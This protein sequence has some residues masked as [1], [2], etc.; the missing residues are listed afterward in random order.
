MPIVYA[1]ALLIGLALALGSWARS[2]RAPA[3][4]APA[5]AG[6]ASS[7]AATAPPAAEEPRDSDPILRTSEGLRRKVV[8]KQLGVVCRSD[9]QGGR[10]VGAP[11][12]YFAICFLYGQR[13]DEDP[14]V[15]QVGPREGPAQ[16]W[17][18]ASAVLEWDTRLMARPTPRRGRPPLVIYREE[19]CLLDVL[20]R[21]TCPRHRGRCPTEGEEAAAGSGTTAPA[22]GMP[23]LKSR[24]LHQADGSTRTV[25]RVASL[26]RD[27]GRPKPPPPAPPAEL[28]PALRQ[29]DIAFVIDTTASMQATIDAARSLAQRLVADAAQRHRDVALR[30]GLVAYRDTSPV[31][32]YRSKIVSPLTDP[33]SFLLALRGLAA[34]QRADGSIEESVLDGVAQALPPLPGERAGSA[35]LQ[36]PAGRSGELATKLVVLLGDAPDHARDLARAEALAAHARTAGITIATVALDRPGVLSRAERARYEAQWRALAA[37]SFLPRDKASG[38]ARRVAPLNL[39]PDEAGRLVPLLESIIDDRIEHARDLAALAAA[40]AEGRLADYVNAQGLRLDQVAPVLVD[41]HRGEPAA[42]ARPDPRAQGK[43]APSVRTGWIAER[44]QGQ[45]LVTVEILMT[46]A[47]LDALVSELTQLQMAAQGTARELSDLLQIGTAAAAGETSFLAAD[48]GRQTFADHLRRRRGLPPARPDSL[49]QRT[50]ADLL[51]SD[52]AAR[53]ALDARL[54]SSLAELIRLRHTIAWDDPQRTV[55]GMALIPYALVDF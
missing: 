15:L 38:F 51:Q 52:D 17:V 8:V 9:P 34:A 43:K 39:R 30:L 11:L 7:P 2:P 42:A 49:L 37:G 27:Q 32:G 45:P 36:W 47:E 12:D 55:D 4:N 41:L 16:G 24:A 33:P 13:P 1:A 40:E 50:Q 3:R 31:F 10:P 20:A 21:R 48:R 5:T 23:I 29:V 19:S 6:Q 14:T 25:F 28:L 26:V 35:H 46:R 53:A 18:P 54:A 22:L 44:Q